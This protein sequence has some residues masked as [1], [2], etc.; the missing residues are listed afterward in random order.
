MIHAAQASKP[1]KASSTLGGVLQRLLYLLSH[2]DEAAPLLESK[3]LPGVQ[4]PKSAVPPQCGEASAVQLRT[5]AR[6]GKRKP[7][8][9]GEAG[10]PPARK[11]A[12]ALA[13]SPK[14]RP[15]SQP[16]AMS[17]CGQSALRR[18][19]SHGSQSF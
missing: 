9:E 3:G 4:S 1:T 18:L 16:H 8:P 7:A 17:V 13:D 2:P 5:S 11:R 19:V 12:C 15:C 10:H 14:V 6:K